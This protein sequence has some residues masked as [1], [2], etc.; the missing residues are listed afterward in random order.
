MLCG[1]RVGDRSVPVLVAKHYRE[2]KRLR[3]PLRDRG[4]G[5]YYFLIQ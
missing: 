2:P 5:N 1:R 3:L 4:E